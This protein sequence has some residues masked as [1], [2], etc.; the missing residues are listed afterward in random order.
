MTELKKIL[1]SIKPEKL[2]LNALYGEKLTTD[3]IYSMDET[4]ENAY[5]TFLAYLNELYPTAN[6]TT[7][8]DKL[9]HFISTYSEIYLEIGLIAGFVLN[10]EME[11]KFQSLGLDT[12]IDHIANPN[13][14]EAA[15]E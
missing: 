7:L 5:D 4:L 14:S 15:G 3:H 9:I 1:D 12:V 2:V 10:K 11:T 13:K 8:D 6:P